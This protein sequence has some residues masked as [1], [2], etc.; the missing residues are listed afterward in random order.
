M[1]IR[2]VGL[3]GEQVAPGEIGEIRVQKKGV[4][5]AYIAR[6]DTARISRTDGSIPAISSPTAK[7]SRS[8]IMGALTT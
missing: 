5:T 4:P 8:S 3:N 2:V 1:T 6:A 7:E